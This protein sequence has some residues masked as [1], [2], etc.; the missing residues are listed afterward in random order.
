MKEVTNDSHFKLGIIPQWAGRRG[1]QEP[2]YPRKKSKKGSQ[3]KHFSFPGALGDEAYNQ[4]I[5]NIG[6]RIEIADLSGYVPGFKTYKLKYYG[7]ITKK[8]IMDIK[9]CKDRLTSPYKPI[10]GK[11]GETKKEVEELTTIEV[12]LTEGSKNKKSKN[13]SKKITMKVAIDFQQTS[14]QP[15]KEEELGTS[16]EGFDGEPPSTT[17]I[18]KVELIESRNVSD[19]DWFFVVF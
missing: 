16:S 9:K 19:A 13:E 6:F 8:Q 15:L 11:D 3:K 1:L 17:G 5:D 2:E 14:E 4:T 10:I 7:T 18:L 12:T